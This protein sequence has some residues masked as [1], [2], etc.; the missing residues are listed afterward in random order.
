MEEIGYFFGSLAPAQLS[1]ATKEMP[2]YR[3]VTSGSSATEVSMWLFIALL[4]VT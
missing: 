2:G 4:L 1:P 3:L